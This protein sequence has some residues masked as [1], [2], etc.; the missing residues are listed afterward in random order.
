[1]ETELTHYQKYKETIIRCAKEYNQRPENMEK[2]RIASRKRYKML[3]DAHKKLQEINA[4]I[5]N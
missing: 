4:L 2:I 3:A 1:M 5:K